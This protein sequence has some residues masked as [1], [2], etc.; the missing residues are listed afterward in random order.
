MVWRGLYDAF[1]RRG[2]PWEIGPR[3]E[4]VELVRSGRLSP[5]ERPRA[6]DL[7]CGSGANPVFL[8]QSGFDVTGVD[9]SPV[10]L[11][12]ARDAAA[13]TGVQATCRF[14]EGDLTADAGGI[15]GPFD[16]IVDYGTLD[17]LRGRGR[18]AMT[19][20]VHDLSAPGTMFL[21]W[22]FQSPREE[23]PWISFSGPSRLAPGLL[24]GEQEERFGDAFDIEKLPEPRPED[25]AAC[26]L[27][28]RR[29]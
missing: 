9:F 12:K 19:R 1:Y 23:L 28:T 25:H 8:A 26:Y 11:S 21:L 29:A 16:L 4:L 10:G 27:L 7:G 3:S 17:D 2:A 13:E 14:V 6:V 20:L 15:T 24:P 22:C 5:D 18:D